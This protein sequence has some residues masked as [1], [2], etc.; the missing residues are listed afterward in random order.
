MSPDPT[1][2]ISYFSLTAGGALLSLR[3]Q[4]RFGG[5]ARLPRCQSL[6][7]G[8]CTPFDSISEAMP[9]RFIEGDTVVCIM[10]AG[11]VVRLLAPHLGSKHSDPAVLVIDEEGRFVV[12]LLGGHAAGAN[13]LAREIAA[14]LGAEAVVT[15]A[16]DVLGVVAPDEVAL[17]LGL[18]VTDPV[19]LRRVTSVLVSGGRV[20]IESPADPGVEGYAW[21]APGDDASGHDARLV[22]SHASGALPD[23]IP[24]ARLVPRTVV[25]GVGCRR[26]TSAE[27]IMAAVEEACRR[28]G[29]DK[30]ALGLMASVEAKRDEQGMSGAAAALGVPM[31]FYG[32]A[33]LAAL[34]RP[35]SAFVEEAVGT[36]AVSEPAA[37]LAAGEGGELLLA[38]TRSESVTVALA[39]RACAPA[40]GEAEDTELTNGPG[41]IY[42]VGT[43]SG[44]RGLL[45]PDAAAAIAGADAVIGYRT[46]IEQLRPLFPDKDY[47]SGSMGREMERCREAVE[48]AREGLTVA[49]VSSGDAGVYGM[50][51]PVLEMAGDVPVE[52]VPGVTA[53]LIGASRVGAPLMNDYISLS[54]SDLLTPRDEV[55]RRCRAAAASDMVVCLYNPTSRKRQ[56]LFEEACAELLASRPPDTVV[57]LVRDAGGPE[58]RAWTCALGELVRQPVD[59]RTIIFVGNSKTTLVGGRMVTLRGY[60]SPVA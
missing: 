21:I 18:S 49:V 48:L 50:A 15:T 8:H 32:A 28:A 41:I 40:K 12:P 46:Y 4:E 23:D 10:S 24:T 26:G 44:A 25:A 56:P 53:A 17:R 57:G 35:G 59:M 43:G 52:V 54:L 19:A 20:C 38:K 7:C 13:R 31:S 1:D 27:E 3:L 55:I 51:G 11:I 9:E 33:E 37:L 58:E 42:V 22:V 2:H 5:T 30:L 39:L 29:V 6:G 36:P 16:S 47:R 60:R 34:G 45:T 14:Y